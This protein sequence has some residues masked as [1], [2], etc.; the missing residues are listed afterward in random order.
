[1]EV[2][3]RL[4]ASDILRRFLGCVAH[5]PIGNVLEAR[6]V[7]EVFGGPKVCAFLRLW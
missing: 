6:D 1:M 2:R 5:A 4:A 7:G 3:S